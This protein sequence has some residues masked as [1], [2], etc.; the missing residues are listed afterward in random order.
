MADLAAVVFD[1]DGL[2]VDTESPIFEMCRSALVELGHDITVE[3]WSRVVGLGD[4]ES[5]AALCSVVGHDID[6]E[7]YDEVYRRQDRAWYDSAPAQEAGVPVG[8]ASSSPAHW[9]ERHLDRLGLRRW[10]T[11]I[12]SEDRVGGRAKP[13][14]D[15]Y[16]LAC[17]DLDVEPSH[18]VAL[19]DSAHG[20]TAALTAGL[21]VVAVPSSIT[22]H[23]DL[24]AAHHTVPSLSA[25][26]VD[27]LQQLV[28]RTTP[29]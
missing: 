15:T 22:A 23:T 25:L 9:I 21:S 4:A 13:L 10:F 14:P 26:T 5:F 17:R 29:G 3:A 12:A 28:A 7:A 1:F 16:L 2:I 20:I 18:A 11:T 8:V 6:R 24:S 19:E 27:D